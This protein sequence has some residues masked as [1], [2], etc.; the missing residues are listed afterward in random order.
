LALAYVLRPVW[1]LAK[2]PAALRAYARARRTVQVSD[3][4]RDRGGRRAPSS[5]PAKGPREVGRFHPNNLRAAWWAVRTARRTRRLLTASGLDA[6]LAPPPPPSLPA[7][8]E[9]GVQG[10]LRRWGESCLV[11]AIVLQAWEAAH[12]RPRDLVIGTTGPEGFRAHAWLDGDP[13]LKVE[14]ADFDRSLLD[15]SRGEGRSRDPGQPH[16]KAECGGMDSSGSFNE[17]LRRPAPDYQRTRSV[18][19]P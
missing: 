3:R 2:L 11:N 6:A 14:G 7:A 18:P 4:P 19:A 16:A 12:G 10:G 1:L 8:A 9:R 5:R 13:E 15:F 17:L